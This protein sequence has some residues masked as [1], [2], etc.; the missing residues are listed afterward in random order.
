MTLTKTVFTVLTPLTLAL[1]LPVHASQTTTCTKTD[2]KQ[3]AQLFDRWNTAVKSSDP[4]AV[5][6][7]YTRDAVL[8]PTLSNQL[9]L[10]EAARIDYFTF[11]LDKKP[12]GKIDS[13]R[14]QIGC[15]SAIDTGLYTFTFADKSTAQARYTFTYA[16]LNGKWLI[17]SHHSSLMPETVTD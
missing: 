15:N 13:R 3:I 6:A 8:L 17:T 5:A 2:T 9:R 12:E 1:P 10:D 14:I 4:E 16:W 11:F 7:Q